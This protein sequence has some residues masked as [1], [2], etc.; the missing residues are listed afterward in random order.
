MK[1]LIRLK[2]FFESLSMARPVKALEED[3]SSHGG[4]IIL[5]C[6]KILAYA[7]TFSRN[8]WIKEISSFCSVFDYPVKTKAK[9][10]LVRKWLFS[11]NLESF[12]NA[13]VEDMEIDK[14][15]KSFEEILPELLLAF[16]RAAEMIATNA[17]SNSPRKF[18][19]ADIE[20]WFNS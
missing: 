13:V 3:C 12:Y 1:I 7:H 5:H 11:R 20:Q 16:D 14:P 8:K 10:P 2:E 17:N 6:I 4:N 18:L 15:S 9:I 19:K